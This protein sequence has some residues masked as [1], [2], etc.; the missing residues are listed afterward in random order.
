MFTTII[1]ELRKRTSSNTV[2]NPYQNEKV[3]NNLQLYFE[4]LYKNN[5]NNILFIGEAPGYKGCRITGIPFTSGELFTN[6]E[7]K[8]FKDLKDEIFL[9]KIESE[10]TAT[11]IWNYLKNKDNLPIFWNSFPYHPFNID[12][13]KSNRA[14]NNEEIEEGKFYIEELVKIFNPKIIAS[15]GR[16]G[17]KIL[18]DMYPNNNIK[19]IRHPSYGGKT[20]FIKGMDEIYNK[21]LERNI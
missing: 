19:Y 5:Q 15:I 12:N 11:I 4:Y 7:I 6:S 1:N 20:D 16:K 14:P 10:N 8:I 18:K 17:E 3:A 21:A 9:E 13:P 2:F